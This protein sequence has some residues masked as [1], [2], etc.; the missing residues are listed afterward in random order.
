MSEELPVIPSDNDERFL[1]ELEFVQN[2]CNMKYLQYLAQMKYFDDEAFM[3]F[4]I[5][6]QYWKQP[7]YTKHLIFPQCLSILD[8]LIHKPAFRK[9]L[10]FAQFIDFCHQQ[11]GLSWLH[12]DKI[13]K[14]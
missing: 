7:N 13:T 5:Y 8:A 12:S 4:L 2:L 3:N 11:Q 9:E 6:L 14:S 1:I 10:P